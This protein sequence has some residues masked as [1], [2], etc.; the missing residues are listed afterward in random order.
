MKTQYILHNEGAPCGYI[1]QVIAPKSL[2]R[3]LEQHPSGS[4]VL[5]QTDWDFPSLAR[6]MAWDM[7]GG[8]CEHDGTDGTIDCSCGKTASEFI[9]EAQEFLDSKMN[10]IHKDEYGLLADYFGV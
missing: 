7:R 1:L 4:S 2:V 10:F 9:R 3:E 6:N 8:N 5:F